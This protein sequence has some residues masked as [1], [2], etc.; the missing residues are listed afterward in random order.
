MTKDHI[1]Y[2]KI[3]ENLEEEILDLKSKL[4]RQKIVIKLPDGNFDYEV[5]K[6]EGV[7]NKI[8]SDNDEFIC[9]SCNGRYWA[10]DNYKY[11]DGEIICTSCFEDGD[12]GCNE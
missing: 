2:E 12:G 5:I 6:G 4:D 3:I 1:N 9:S 10:L 7:Q 11:Y 8:L